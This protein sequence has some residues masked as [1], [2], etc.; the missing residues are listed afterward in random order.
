MGCMGRRRQAAEL[1]K[2]K[3]AKAATDKK[4]AVLKEHTVPAPK[5]KES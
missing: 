4:K 5:R 1:K 2:I 3:D